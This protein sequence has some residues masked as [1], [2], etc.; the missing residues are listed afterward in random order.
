VRTAFYEKIRLK[1]KYKSPFRTFKVNGITIIQLEVKDMAGQY[2]GFLI[3][4]VSALS[5]KG[6]MRT[7]G[8]MKDIRSVDLLWLEHS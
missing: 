7:E 1:N 4:N 8:G 2:F 6:D 5:S 3:F